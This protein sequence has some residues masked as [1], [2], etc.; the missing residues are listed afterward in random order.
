MR[1]TGLVAG[2]AVALWAAPA[3]TA[4]QATA[5]PASF[6]VTGGLGGSLYTGGEE[7]GDDDAGLV[8][9]GQVSYQTGPHIL[10]LR[11]SII[12]EIFDDA[13]SDVGVLYG[14]GLE[15][16]TGHAS[17]AAGVAW[18]YA[19]DCPG[20]LFSSGPCTTENTVGVPIVAEASFRPWSFVGI[21]GQA[22]VNL[23]AARTVFGVALILQLG[24]LY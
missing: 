11:G 4:G 21:G 22:A 9:I 20:G 16:E 23:N 2:M 10:S 1:R 3:A 15:G 19:E 13:L 7:L 17:I 24:A 18:V 5:R 12:A 14:R 8:L 6:W